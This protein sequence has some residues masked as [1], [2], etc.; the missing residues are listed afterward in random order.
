MPDDDVI[1]T[2]ETTA[3]TV[4]KHPTLEYGPDQRF[5][6]IRGFDSVLAIQFI[7]AIEEALDVMLSE[8]EVDRMDTMGDLVEIVRLKLAAR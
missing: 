1:S 5:R 2:I 8:E 6:A 4:F 3:R 7:L